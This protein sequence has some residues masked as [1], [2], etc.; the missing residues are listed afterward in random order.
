MIAAFD[1]LAQKHCVLGFDKIEAMDGLFFRVRNIPGAIAELGVYRGGSARFLARSFP[2][3][4]CFFFDTFEGMPFKGDIDRHNPGDFSDTSIEAVREVLSDCHNAEIVPGLFPESAKPYFGEQFAFVH[5]DADQYQSTKDGLEFFWPRM[6]EGGIIVL[7][8]YRWKDC[9]GVERALIEFGRPVKTTVPFQAYLIKMTIHEEESHAGG[10]PAQVA[11]S[12]NTSGSIPILVTRS[13][14][15]A[16]ITAGAISKTVGVCPFC[17]ESTIAPRAPLNGFECKRCES[18][19]LGN[20]QGVTIE[21]GVID[22]ITEARLLPDELAQSKEDEIFVNG[23]FRRN[24]H[25]SQIPDIT[26]PSLGGVA[27]AAHKAGYRIERTEHSLFLIR[28]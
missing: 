9:P 16:T 1:T 22:N 7:D 3:R 27:I 24:A 12:E 28:N 6:A 10:A 21:H 2:D 26:L 23:P 4:D 11:A 15:T 5:L 17:G 18:V 20:G 13:G 25:L 19:F 14:S 8:D